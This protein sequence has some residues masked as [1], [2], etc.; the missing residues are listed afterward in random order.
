[1]ARK[2]KIQGMTAKLVVKNKKLYSFQYLVK[3]KVNKLM[4]FSAGQSYGNMGKQDFLKIPN[5]ALNAHPLPKA[6]KKKK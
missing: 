5:N 4:R 2:S 1:M 3:I 6:D